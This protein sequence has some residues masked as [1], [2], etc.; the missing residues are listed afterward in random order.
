MSIRTIAET[1]NADKGT[2]RKILSGELNMKNVC[3]KLVPKNV[4]RDRKFVCQQICSGF[5][6]RLDEDPEL[7]EKIIICYET[8]IF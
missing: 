2:V 7:M 4:T 1:V 8:W 6:E 5:L 3:A